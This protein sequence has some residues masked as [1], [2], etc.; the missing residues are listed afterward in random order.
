LHIEI[1][2]IGRTVSH[3]RIVDRLG[4]GGMAVVYEAEDLLLG[5]RVA[6]KFL[7]P[8]AVGDELLS[9]RL[10]REARAA[11][12]LDHPGIC[13]VYEVGSHEGQ[14]FI[15]MA[16]VRG[17]TLAEI[18]SRE[19]AIEVDEAL[20]IAARVA[21]ALRA[22]HQQGIVH[23]DIK[24]SN[25]IV[26]DDGAV[27]ILDFGLAV[28][29]GGS[30]DGDRRIL[31]TP[32]YMAPE[33][34]RGEV[35]A[36]SGDVW[37][38]G[39]LAYEILTGARPFRGSRTS[40]VVQQ[41][42]TSDPDP[43]STL[44]P[45]LSPAVEHVIMR[46]LHRDVARRFADGAELVAAL[47]QARDETRDMPPAAESAT[48]A[49]RSVA[50]LAFS[51]LSPGS[52]H[53]Y[54]CDGVAEEIINAL[55]QVDG[56]RVASRTSSFAFKH[57]DEDARTIGRRLGVRAV[58][59][60]SVRKAGSRIRITCEMVDVDDGLQLWSEKFDRGL[61]DVFAVQEEIAQKVVTAFSLEMSGHERA[62]LER[63]GTRDVAAYDF[64]LR[65][66][67]LFYR[68]RRADIER[69]VAMFEAAVERDARYARAW[70]ALASCHAYLHMYFGGAAEQLSRADEASRRALELD[71]ALADAHAAHGL[72]LSFAR[73]Y[74]Q[75][76]QEYRRAIEL[77]PALFEAWYFY[78]RTCFSRGRHEDA[79]R[80]FREAA[81]V[82]PQDLQAVSLLA[83]VYK[84]LGRQEENLETSRETLRRVERHLANNPDD[85]RAL[86]LGASALMELDEPER[87]WS[88]ARRCV[89]LAPADPYNLYGIACLH[90]KTGDVESALDYLTRA[91]TAGFSHVEWLERDSD[92]ESLRDNPLFEK[93]VAELVRKTGA[94]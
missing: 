62:A 33:L 86:Y 5:R 40:Q 38:W 48:G 90:G 15:A 31:G 94:H 2:M 4:A 8:R 93:I 26:A 18:I 80:C 20:R 57:R 12:A 61:D 23:R 54:F 37:S 83:F 28:Q 35:P 17:R 74:E 78:G 11:A 56:L 29:R 84:C 25:V 41:I 43:P 19:G 71:A 46:A 24:S 67:Q 82:S 30:E 22:A 3:F 44:K 10:E 87:A 65:G 75:A 36:A 45:D 85:A 6:L 88:W 58:L 47:E 39:V 1:P 73:D 55:S 14:L 50:V 68:S 72:I 59:G 70:A 51:D 9:A 63:A 79:V 21:E 92:F 64:Y 76:E 32:A 34:L 89:E 60:G 13:T 66:R 49:D 69:A 52:D 77:D 53:E 91:I 27:K 7:G 16:L 81:R 42:L